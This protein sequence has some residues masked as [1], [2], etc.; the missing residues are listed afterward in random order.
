MRAKERP[1]QSSCEN[2]RRER[3]DFHLRARYVCMLVG[4]RGCMCIYV[5]GKG[6]IEQVML[7][8]ELVLEGKGKYGGGA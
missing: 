1:S 5:S 3:D 8:I 7:G 4:P 2:L 6:F